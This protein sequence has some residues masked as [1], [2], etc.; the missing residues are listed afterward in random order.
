[1]DEYFR[2]FPEAEPF[3][4]AES[5]IDEEEAERLM[6]MAIKRG[7]PLTKEERGFTGEMTEAEAREILEE[8]GAI[9]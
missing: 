9:E 8:L 2:A 4:N 6:R 5:S 1:M 3:F 7:K